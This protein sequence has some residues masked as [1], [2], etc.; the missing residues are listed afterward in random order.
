MVC[1]AVS[2]CKSR[3]EAHG[4]V[5]WSAAWKDSMCT[6]RERMATVDS[7]AKMASL[8]QMPH[9]IRYFALSLSSACVDFQ[10]NALSHSGRDI[11]FPELFYRCIDDQK[12]ESLTGEKHLGARAK[13]T[14]H[15]SR[16]DR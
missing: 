3:R 2:V 5:V 9:A 10:R 8:Y 6:H 1:V 15:V 12:D 14:E 7:V 4:R 13:N 16:K 11:F